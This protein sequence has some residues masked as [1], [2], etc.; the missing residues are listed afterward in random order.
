MIETVIWHSLLP[1]TV[2]ENIRK[3]RKELKLSQSDL[4]KKCNLSSYMISKMERGKHDFRITE[5]EKI[6]FGLNKKI[7]QVIMK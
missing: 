5:I 3:F 7:N 1:Q 2:G 4:A 6:S